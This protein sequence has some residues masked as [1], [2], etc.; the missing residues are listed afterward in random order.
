M[1]V[2]LVRAYHPNMQNPLA[3]VGARG[4]MLPE[5]GS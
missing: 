3:R 1:V 2:V 5:A 4:P